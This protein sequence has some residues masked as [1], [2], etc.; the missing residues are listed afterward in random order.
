[1]LNSIVKQLSNLPGW[2]T[3]RKIVVIE[4]D[5]WGSVRIKDKKAFDALDRAGLNVKEKHFDSYD[6]LESNEDLEMLFDALSSV[7]DSNKR[8]AVFSP[9]CILGNPDLRKIN[10]NGFTEYH[11][12]PLKDTIKEY[13]RS[14]NILKLWNEGNSLKI[15]D[16][17]LHGREHVNVNRFMDILMSHPGKE[18]LRIAVKNKSL[19]PSKYK[20]YHYSNYLGALHPGRK[21][22]ISNLHSYIL[23]AGTLFKKYTGLSPKV[24]VAPDAEEPKELEKSLSKIGVKFLTR[25]KHRMYPVGDGYYKREWNFLGQRN[26]LGQVIINRNCSFEPCRISKHALGKKGLESCM[27]DIG[28]AFKWQKPAVISTHRVNY[29]SGI[30]KKNREKGIRDLKKLLYQ[31]TQTWEDVEFMASSELG[32]LVSSE[33]S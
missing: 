10:E 7:L 19:G 17:G 24:F 15:F 18:G 25:S 22:E 13:P 32:E 30:Q 23:E 5:D 16:L 8:S 12:Q 28:I 14:D 20:N 9:M 2:R 3:K 11:F 33:L 27:K 6:T 21:D 4:S 26:N 31:I 29:V 1:M